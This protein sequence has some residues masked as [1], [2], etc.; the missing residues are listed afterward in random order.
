M[1]TSNEIIVITRTVNA[2]K[3]VGKFVDPTNIV[4]DFSQPWHSL[5]LRRKSGAEGNRDLTA[6]N[7]VDLGIRCASTIVD[8]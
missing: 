4:L 8:P 5:H 2:R 6:C 1:R 3:L 7:I